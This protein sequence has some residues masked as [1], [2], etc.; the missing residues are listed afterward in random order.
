MKRRISSKWTSALPV[1]VLVMYAPIVLLL[2]VT[3]DAKSV[4]WW[5]FTSLVVL[6]N[7]VGLIFFP[8]PKHVDVDDQ[9]IT[10]TTVF[11][12]SS[13]TLPLTA[14]DEIRPSLLSKTVAIFLC[15][16]GCS[17]AG[18][19]RLAGVASYGR[20]GVNEDSIFG[21]KINFMPASTMLSHPASNLA[22]KTFTCSSKQ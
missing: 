16:G 18:C 6:A 2:V 3:F 7:V 8:F 14:I 9:G 20:G 10:V 19:D 21:R 22:T 5:L 1:L 15:S 4:V 13:V 12:N 17:V 11:G